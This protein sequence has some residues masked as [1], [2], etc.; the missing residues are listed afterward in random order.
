MDLKQVAKN[1]A[2]TLQSYLTYQAMRT[3][4]AQL[5][6]TNPPKA[7]WLHRFS[8]ENTI[9]D[10]EAYLQS[11]LAA[12]PDLAFRLMTVRDQLVTDVADYLPE[13]LREGVY[14]SN[15]QFR[16]QH[17]ERLTQLVLPEDPRL[18]S[19][20]EQFLGDRPAEGRSALGDS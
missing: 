3:V 10:G 16:R 20:S 5:H 7:L 14:K 13:M 2:K 12:D 9:Q 4:L 11:L 17:L 15:A 8:A 6:E 19:E 1:T 18:L